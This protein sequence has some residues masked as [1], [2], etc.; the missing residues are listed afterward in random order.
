[1]EELKHFKILNAINVNE[2][3]EVKDDGQTKLTYLS[4][5][6]AWQEVKKQFPEAIYEIEKF[7]NN[8]PYV[9]DEKTGYMVLQPFLE[10]AVLHG[11]APLSSNGLLQIDIKGENN[12]L[13]ITIADNGIGIEKSKQL[14]QTKKHNSRGMQLIKERLEILS[15]Q[16]QQPV[17]LI[18][19]ENNTGADN[20][21]TKVSLIIPQA[22]FEQL[23]K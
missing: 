8:L 22:I 4:W 1:M 21:G 2:K 5:A 13:H 18:I 16:A 11:L 23:K 20:P 17:T 6:W 15:S 3:T 19:G 10:N 14:R 9:Y 7:E 12:A